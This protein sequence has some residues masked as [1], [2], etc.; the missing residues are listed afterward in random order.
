MLMMTSVKVKPIRTEVQ[1]RALDGELDGM[2]KLE[3]K[4]A[5]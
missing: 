2:G 1:Q 3:I 4:D 5:S